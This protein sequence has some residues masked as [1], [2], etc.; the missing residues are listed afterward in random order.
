MSRE[1][2]LQ[3]QF[4]RA[5]ESKLKRKITKEVWKLLIDEE[6]VSEALNDP[7]HKDP[8][9]WLAKR[10]RRYL[11]L[12]D[13]AAPRPLIK[14]PRRFRKLKAVP[15]RLQV[16]SDLIAAEA[17]HDK[18]VQAFRSKYMDS[19]LVEPNS[20]PDWIER[21]AAATEYDDALIV[22]VPKAHT[23]LTGEIESYPSFTV[24]P[25]MIEQ[26]AP[27][28][29][30]AFATLDSRYVR[31]R[32]VGRDGV[33]RELAD[34]AEALALKF[35][36]QPAQATTFILTDY[37]PLLGQ[38]YVALQSPPYS[39]WESGGKRE[40][41]CLFRFAI[42]IDVR[43]S[44]REVAQLLAEARQHFNIPRSHSLS[45]K[46]MLLASFVA[47][48]GELKPELMPLWNRRHPK[49]TYKRFSLFSRDARAAKTRLLFAP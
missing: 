45:E 1:E 39:R 44:A 9:G 20:V 32:P 42:T 5:V 38:D 29:V 49:W 10:A 12:Q 22:R 47:Q 24:T 3:S 13:T 11:N 46:H 30:L 28:I 48:H 34:L 6:A 2:L 17:R 4:R 14:S 7:V 15:L 18:R 25:D 36:W 8:V 35:S 16:V 41:N 27:S 43:R 26:V 21:N 33:L 23:L 19:H 37:V 40:L 31:R